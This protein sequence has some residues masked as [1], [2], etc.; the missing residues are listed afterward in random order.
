LRRIIQ[1]MVP[2]L[3]Y[4]PAVTIRVNPHS[5]SEVGEEIERLDPDLVPKIQLI[6]TDRMPLGDIRITFGKGSCTR[7]GTEIWQQ[8]YDIL[9]PHDLIAP[10]DVIVPTET[11]KEIEHV[12]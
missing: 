3:Q 7:S 10:H 5:A 11:T 1:T 4:K 9:A 12:E 6:P 2:P 8:I